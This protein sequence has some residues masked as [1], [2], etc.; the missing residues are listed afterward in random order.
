MDYI[1]E[2]GTLALASRLRRFIDKLIKDGT[3]VYE[4]LDFEFEVR[5]FPIFHLLSY[6]SPLTVMQIA[7]ALGL[8]HPSI[9]ETADEMA[10]RAL[11]TSYRDDA[12][13]RRRL[14]CLTEEG[15]NLAVKLEPVWKAFWEAADD[16]FRE[17]GCDLLDSIEKVETVLEQK[18]FYERIVARLDKQ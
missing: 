9:I 15:K 1:E 11:V 3:R 14:L 13:K 6:H 12:D 5:W 10:R 18:T 8:A 7:E 2:L 17:A 4:S 16:V